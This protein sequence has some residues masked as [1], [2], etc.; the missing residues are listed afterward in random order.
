MP[1]IRFGVSGGG[2][3]PTDAVPWSGRG[4]RRPQGQNLTEKP[5]GSRTWPG[6][7]LANGFGKL[8]PKLD[9]Q[10]QRWYPS[11][12][13]ALVQ[14]YELQ[15]SRA[16]KLWCS[17]EAEMGWKLVPRVA[18]LLH[19]LRLSLRPALAHPIPPPPAIRLLISP[20]PPS[21]PPLPDSPTFLRAL[22]LY[23]LFPRRPLASRL[24][25]AAGEEASTLCPGP[26]RC[27]GMRI[28]HFSRG[29]WRGSVCARARELE[30]KA[31]R[32]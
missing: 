24:L 28:S 27:S 26:A 8:R 1:A 25:G 21:S 19:L 4:A 16:N 32:I 29:I 5:Q 22:L 2:G 11:K 13:L 7:E 15:D 3:S 23:S 31:G 30:A 9:P 14:P 10:G 6:L 18:A 17:R 20:L 12:L